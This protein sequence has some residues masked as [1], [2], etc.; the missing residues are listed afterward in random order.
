DFSSSGLSSFLESFPPTEFYSDAIAARD[1]VASGGMFN[2]I[3]LNSADKIDLWAHKARGFDAVAFGRR[4]PVDF[5]GT[6]IWTPRPED[7]ILSK[8][9][10]SKASGGSAVQRRD[11]L[12][13]LKLNAGSID[14]KYLDQWAS[15]I[16]VAEELREISAPFRPTAS[17]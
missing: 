7:L 6:R 17:G 8:L 15:Q 13:I 4:I 2:I 10:W 3:N 9:R 12:G 11:V 14:W 1:A 16:G 5:D